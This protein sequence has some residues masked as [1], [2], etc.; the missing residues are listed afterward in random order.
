MKNFKQHFDEKPAGE[1]SYSPL[2]TSE[3]PNKFQAFP[4]EAC[5]LFSDD[6]A[7]FDNQPALP[8]AT[9]KTAPLAERP[10]A[11]SGVFKT[12]EAKTDDLFEMGDEEKV[13]KASKFLMFKSNC[14]ELFGNDGEEKGWFFNH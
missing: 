7:H 11:A 1:L 9:D 6:S 8:E 2:M 14:D 4:V 10:E 3:N 5:Q 13:E 12:F